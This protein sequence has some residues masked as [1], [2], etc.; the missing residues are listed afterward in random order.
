MAGE[1][2]G[3]SVGVDLAGGQEFTVLVDGALQ[4]KLVPGN[5]MTPIASGLSNGP[6]RIEIYRRT[7]ALTA[8]RH[9]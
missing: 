6:H 8:T 5:G 1:R 2:V 4:P 7:E 9:C 3:T